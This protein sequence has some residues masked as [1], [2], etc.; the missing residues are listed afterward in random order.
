MAM[1]DAD[2]VVAGIPP[3]SL[4]TCIFTFFA[5]HFGINWLAFLAAYDS[6]GVLEES[7]HIQWNE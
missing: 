2:A 6:I 1:T 7:A 5:R 4:S 3:I